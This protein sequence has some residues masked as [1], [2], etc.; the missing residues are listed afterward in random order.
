M[1][2]EKEFEAGDIVVHRLTKEEMLVLRSDGFGAYQVPKTRVRT[3]NMEALMLDT[4]ELEA[5][6]EMS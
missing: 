5:S 6:P 1:G 4:E 2:N 3:K